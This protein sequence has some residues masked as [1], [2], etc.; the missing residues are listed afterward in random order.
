MEENESIEN[1]KKLEI[2]PEKI[3]LEKIDENINQLKFCILFTDIKT[4]IERVKHYLPIITNLLKI[5]INKIR[6][7]NEYFFV[8]K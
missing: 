5:C 6:K 4:D 1:I 3:L 8:W 7:K 2:E